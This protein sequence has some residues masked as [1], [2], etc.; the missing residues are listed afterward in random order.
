MSRSPTRF[1]IWPAAVLTAMLVLISCR[2]EAPQSAWQVTADTAAGMLR[3]TNTPPEP[4]PLPTLLGEEEFRVGTVEG[5]GPE[6]FG[7]IRQL[8][9][10]PDSRFA[11]AD[12][13]AEEV[14]LFD[15]EGRH[16]QTFGGEGSGPGELQGLQGVHV[17]AD[18]M[19]RVAEQGNARLTVFDPDS[20]F[21]TTYPLRL[22]SYGFRGPW[23]AAVDSAGRTLVASS[24]QYGEGRFWNMV[25]VYDP[26][27]KQLDSIPYR[28]YTDLARRAIGGGDD[29][30]FPGVWRV[31]LGNGAWTWAQVPFYS[32][33]HQV[34]AP[35]GEFW[36]SAAAQVELEVARWT[37]SGDTSLV[38][39]SRRQPESVTAAE[40]DSAMSELRERLAARVST[41]P[42]LDA[43]RVPASKPPLYGLSVDDAERLWVRLTE[44]VAD[45]TIYDVFSREGRH[46][47]TVWLPFR[48]DQNVPPVVRGDTL[49]AVVTDDMDVQYVIRASLRPPS[50][51]ASP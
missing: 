12:G 34:L 36:S 46:V 32:R 48:V 11:V 4:G 44:P 5:G 45:S 13:Q 20:G 7:M 38:L 19:L 51:H 28:E 25:R 10:L 40:R 15:L 33:P 21:V 41:P 18:G 35:T 29:D 30:D 49:W 17:G 42:S 14:R 8:A 2:E 43:S 23:P 3:V 1:T 50:Q 16:L 26:R 47:E 22:H 9:V 24:G 31:E 27:M 39:T 6:S 37:P